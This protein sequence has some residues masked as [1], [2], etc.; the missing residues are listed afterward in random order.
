ME[1]KKGS[2]EKFQNPMVFKDLLT[3]VV[4]TLQEHLRNSQKE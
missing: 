4:I 2:F 1:S 3:L